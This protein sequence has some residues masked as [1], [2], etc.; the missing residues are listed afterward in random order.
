MYSMLP[1]H[2]QLQ[3][4]YAVQGNTKLVHS[5]KF[6]YPKRC[7][8]VANFARISLLTTQRSMAT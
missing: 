1:G 8:P 3:W 7:I 4:D 6:A 2:L 5:V